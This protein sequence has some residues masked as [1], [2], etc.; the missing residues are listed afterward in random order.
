MEKKMTELTAALAHCVAACNHC[1]DA[2]LREEDVK[3]MAECIKLDKECAEICALALSQSASNS[4][5]TSKTLKL[6]II[7]CNVCADECGKHR[8]DHCRECAEVCRKCAEV[9]REYI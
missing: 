2:C 4:P 9:C 1:F 7:A 3:M 6:C 8:Y 5:F